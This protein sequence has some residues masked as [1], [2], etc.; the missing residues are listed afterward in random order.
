MSNMVT[1]DTCQCTVKARP[2]PHDCNGPYYYY[3]Y[4]LNMKINVA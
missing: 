1:H 3:Y 4:F 2:Q